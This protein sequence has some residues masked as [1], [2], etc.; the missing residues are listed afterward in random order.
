[1]KHPTCNLLNSG[2]EQ[3]V[4]S[5]FFVEYNSNIIM[6][7]VC[8]A[9]FKVWV[10]LSW[11]LW[12]WLWTIVFGPPTFASNALAKGSFIKLMM[13][14]PQFRSECAVFSIVLTNSYCCL[15]KS[16]RFWSCLYTRVT[17]VDFFFFFFKIWQEHEPLYSTSA[18]LILIF[19][20]FP[21]QSQSFEP[22]I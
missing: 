20:P 3:E 9:W 1:M 16:R 6:I 2:Y 10:W 12:A 15:Q 22:S 13:H 4:H 18:W 19:L 14:I 17:S 8:S 11:S 7:T 21:N 5:C